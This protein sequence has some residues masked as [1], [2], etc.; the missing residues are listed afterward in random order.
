MPTPRII[1][2]PLLVTVV[3]TALLLALTAPATTAQQAA[4]QG[5]PPSATASARAGHSC[6]LDDAEHLRVKRWVTLDS[7]SYAITHADRVRLER[8]TS[9]DRTRTVSFT[10]KVSTR[11]EGSA[12]VH[13]E[14]GAF[15]AKASVTVKASVAHQRESTTTESVSDTFHV[16]ARR[17]A[18]RYV[19][20]QGVDYFKM[21]WH[22]L[23]CR[24]PHGELKKG[25]LRT[26]SRA[27]FSGVV[28][29]PHTRYRSGSE[30]YSAALA[31]G[32]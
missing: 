24:L 1:T 8:G 12:E 20:Y 5:V 3:L 4:Q 14:A 25:R 29:C 22:R 32:C 26:Y 2:A 16:P 9:F 27:T 15:F 7:H 31:G 19:F 28:Q 21:H 18:H 11:I 30:P 23:Q 17:H 13:T 10:K 6:N